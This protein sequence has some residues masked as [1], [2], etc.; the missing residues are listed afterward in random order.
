MY[1]KYCCVQ[2]II[3]YFFAKC[4]FRFLLDC[5]IAR[6][7][8]QHMKIQVNFIVCTENVTHNFFKYFNKYLFPAFG[9]KSVF[10]ISLLVFGASNQIPENRHFPRSISKTSC[11]PTYTL[12]Y[13]K[14][15][16]VKDIFKLFQRIFESLWTCV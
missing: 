7:L 16:Q 5:Q 11:T 12:L 1:N 13:N 6:F 9:L 8:K 3:Q 10:I 4:F 14:N 15:I 2:F